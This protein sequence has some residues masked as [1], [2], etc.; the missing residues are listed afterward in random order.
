M[1]RFRIGQ[2]VI[3]VAVLVTALTGLATL[4]AAAPAN[5]APTS[6]VTTGN[7]FSCG[8]MPD[9]TVW[10]WGKNTTG[11]LGVGDD[12]DSLVP[13]WVRTLPPATD[14][15]AGHDHTCAVDT[16]HNVWCW[17]NNAFGQLGNGT[18]LCL[19]FRPRRSPRA[20]VRRAR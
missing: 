20:T 4:R 12:T 19:A 7:G 16:A 2:L 13:E 15:S 8:L 5:A 17:G 18:S 6:M 3:G 11:Q 10:C 1:R 9:Q 14:V